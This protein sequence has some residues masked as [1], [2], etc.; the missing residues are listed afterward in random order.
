MSIVEK[1]WA[2]VHGNYGKTI[3]G[4]QE[5]AFAF[6]CGKPSS[7]FH[8]GKKDKTKSKNNSVHNENPT[9]YATLWAKLFQAN[10]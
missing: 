9:D 6:L 8:F 2:K 1:A 7:Y 5:A 10:Y 4:S 3:E